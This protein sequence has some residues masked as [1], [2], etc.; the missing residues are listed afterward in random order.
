MPQ[1]NDDL[2]DVTSREEWHEYLRE[3]NPEENY[4]FL[5]TFK[6]GFKTA[7]SK[8]PICHVIQDL[9]MDPE[10]IKMTRPDVYEALFVPSGRLPRCPW[11]VVRLEQMADSVP[12]RKS[13]VMVKH[14]KSTAL[15]VLVRNAL[16]NSD[17][18]M[19][20]MNNMFGMLMQHF[21]GQPNGIGMKIFGGGNAL[22]DDG[23]HCPYSARQAG[24]RGYRTGQP[25]ASDSDQRP[26]IQ[27]VFED[28]DIAFNDCQAHGKGRRSFDATQSS[29]PPASEQQFGLRANRSSSVEAAMAEPAACPEDEAKPER[30]KR[31]KTNQPSRQEACLVQDA[32]PDAEIDRER[33][34]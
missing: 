33:H 6:K 25:E 19:A 22:T 27:E 11:D 3:R 34:E 12:M 4:E 1:L 5:Q 31:S 21:G 29:E 9:P 2:E 23:R 10:V 17:T 16:Q 15:A 20:I 26:D 13:H 28:E 7:A 18:P 32:P 24:S 14:S 8:A 30:F